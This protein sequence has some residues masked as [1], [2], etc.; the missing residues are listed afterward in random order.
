MSNTR[1]NS[2]LDHLPNRQSYEAINNNEIVN[3]NCQ[4]NL[5]GGLR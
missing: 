1:K 4:S 2:R 3:N 5:I